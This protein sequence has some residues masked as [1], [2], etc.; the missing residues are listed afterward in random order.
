LLLLKNVD[1]NV[2]DKVDG[3]TPLHY[4][5]ADGNEAICKLLLEHKADST[6]RDN[7][8]LTPLHW[9]SRKG[10]DKIVVCLLDYK[11]DPRYQDRPVNVN[12]QD[13]YGITPLSCACIK[14]HAKSAE[15]LLKHGADPNLCNSNLSS[16]L[17]VTCS[18]GHLE[19]AKLLLLYKADVNAANKDKKTP[20]HFACKRGHVE[21]AA[22]LLKNGATF[23]PDKDGLSPLDGVETTFMDEIKAKCPE[24]FESQNPAGSTPTTSNE[25]AAKN[26]KNLESVQDYES[27]WMDERCNIDI[28]ELSFS[29]LIG[30]GGCGE[31]Y[32]GRWRNTDIAIKKFIIHQSKMQEKDIRDFK[33]EVYVMR[34][35]THPNVILFLAAV[36]KP[37]NLCIVTEYLKHGSLYHV[38]HDK[39]ISMSWKLVLKM[40][41]GTARGMHYLHSMEPKIMHRDLKS[42]NLLVDE[43]WNIKV[44]DFGFAKVKIDAYTHTLCGTPQ[45][46]A[47]EV[48]KRQE[49]DEKTDVYSFGIVLW[50]LITRQTPYSGTR[51]EKVVKLVLEGARPKIPPNCPLLYASLMQKCWDEDSEKRPNFSYILKE[52]AHIQ[53]E[54]VTKAKKKPPSNPIPEISS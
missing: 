48:I 29:Q 9:S 49:Y 14:G 7:N 53:D 31:V 1:V 39:N 44:C 8:G 30:R 41:I 25:D 37:P 42:P 35:L 36:T 38:L 17:H 23:N 51:A 46:M 16:P 4:V 2:K 22:I 10:L 24:I 26:D 32:K 19:I 21:V 15:V 28:R 11:V 18:E 52:L 34:T 43:N 27:L 40:A 33:Q 5:C 54:T 3:L 20:L 13:S 50:E 6:I 47:P 12:I 45:W